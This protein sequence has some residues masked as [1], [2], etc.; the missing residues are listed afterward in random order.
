MHPDPLGVGARQKMVLLK[1]GT[2]IG[3]NN[4]GFELFNI[5]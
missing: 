4:I 1:G 5:Q 2:A 3:I